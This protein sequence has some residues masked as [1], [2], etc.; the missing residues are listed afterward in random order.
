MQN[1]HIFA[2]GLAFS[3]ING[4]FN[5]T[6]L[7]KRPFEQV[8]TVKASCEREFHFNPKNYFEKNKKKKRK[9]PPNRFVALLRICKNKTEQNKKKTKNGEAF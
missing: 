3:L 2:S 1:G 9:L 4:V 8:L 6:F 7:F 5:F